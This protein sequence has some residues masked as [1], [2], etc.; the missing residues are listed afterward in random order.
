MLT[1]DSVD[2]VS[3]KGYHLFTMK[4]FRLIQLLITLG[5]IL[6]I[7]GG[8]ST[9]PSSI[10]K[11]TVS[12]TSKFG[13]GLYI[14]AF[15]G[16]TIFTLISSTYRTV[17]P[18]P[19]DRS[20]IAIA[21]AWP[22]VTVRLVYSSLAVFSLNRMFSITGGNV[23]L[24]ACMAVVE[25]FVVVIDYLVLGYYLQRLEPEQQGEL[26]NRVWRER[27]GQRNQQR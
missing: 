10:N 20:P 1:Y 25:E 6:S 21:I 4:Q 8:S 26:A 11:V 24:H 15:A 22:F 23:A 7:V 5:L 14:I 9:S 13:I 27:R 17:V 19:E 3:A 12:S 2:C 18:I 16:L